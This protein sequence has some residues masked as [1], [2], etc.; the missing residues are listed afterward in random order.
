M[1]RH[2]LLDACC[3][4]TANNLS[5]CCWLCWCV[6]VELSARLEKERLDAR[7]AETTAAKQRCEEQLG[8]VQQVRVGLQQL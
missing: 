7:L 6:Q 3:I 1:Y 4:V 2:H 5:C 8:Q